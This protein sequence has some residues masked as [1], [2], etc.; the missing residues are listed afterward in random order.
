VNVTNSLVFEG[1]LDSHRLQVVDFGE[2][3]PDS[4]HSYCI[5]AVGGPLAITLAWYDLPSSPPS[6]PSI[7]LLI[8]DLD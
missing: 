4:S 7:P 1:S 6:D 3:T 2:L 5:Q 8:N